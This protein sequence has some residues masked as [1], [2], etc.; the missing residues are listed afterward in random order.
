MDIDRSLDDIIEERK[1]DQREK[2]SQ[3]KPKGAA[4][5]NGKKT[6]RRTNS[7][8]IYSKPYERVGGTK[9]EMARQQGNAAARVYVHNLPYSHTWRDLKE[10]FSQAGEVVRADIM[11]TRS[12]QRSRGCGLVE[13]ATVKEAQDAIETLNDTEIDGRKILVREDRERGDKTST[14]TNTNTRKSNTDG[15][16]ASPQQGRQVFVNNLDKSITWQELK[17]AFSPAGE[18]ERADIIGDGR[19]SKG[20]GLILFKTAE[21]AQKA[22]EDF[23]EGELKNK[24]ISVK[25][26]TKVGQYKRA[27]GGAQTQGVNTKP[28]REPRVERGPAP[29]SKRVY[30]HNLPYQ[31]SNEGLQEH[32]AVED[33][34]VVGAEIMRMPNGRSKGCGIVEFESVDMASVAIEKLN[35]SLLDGRNI[36]VREDREVAKKE[37]TAA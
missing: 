6:R 26:D 32:F 22:I 27:T 3:Q 19:L 25:M 2:R 4:A 33:T 36:L 15:E 11:T 14:N 8:E 17:D 16:E 24:T 18:V 5:T 1:N 37:A 30:V 13:F 29:V 9:N 28:A 34:V 21:A 23:H 31:V 7:T 20:Q 35:N 12:T 10:H